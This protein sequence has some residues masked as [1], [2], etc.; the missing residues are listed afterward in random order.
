MSCIRNAT[1]LISLEME[2]IFCSDNYIR[3]LLILCKSTLE[4]EP[5]YRNKVNANARENNYLSNLNYFIIVFSIN[6]YETIL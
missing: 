5:K 4:L 6:V 1:P 2:T 3:L